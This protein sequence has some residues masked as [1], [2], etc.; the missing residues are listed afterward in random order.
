VIT[1]LGIAAAVVLAA[2]SAIPASGGSGLAAGPPGAD[3]ALAKT[4]GNPAPNVGDTITFTVTLTNAGP[5][6]ATSVQVSDLLPEGLSFVSATPS[7]G[8]YDSGTGLWTVGTVTTT[9]PQ[10]LQMSAV[11][12]SPK[13]QTNKAR[14]LTADQADPP[15]ATT[16]RV[17]P[18]LRSRRIWS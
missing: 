6:D 18:R 8:A 12:V 9:A 2:A 15:R 3:L 11:V 4:V 16:R 5:A 17:R 10:T 14:I 13:K 7:K 1:R